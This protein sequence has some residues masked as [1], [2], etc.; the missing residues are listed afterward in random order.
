MCSAQYARDIIQK[1]AECWGR[2]TT[3]LHYNLLYN[4]LFYVITHHYSIFTY[5]KYYKSSHVAY[6]HSICDN[7][8]PTDFVRCQDVTIY[9]G[10]QSSSSSLSIPFFNIDNTKLKIIFI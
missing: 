4:R 9:I 7:S 6:R 2:A 5:L 8:P 1:S 10:I 3:Q